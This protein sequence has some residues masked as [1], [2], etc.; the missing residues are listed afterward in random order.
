M[1]Q[2]AP[3]NRIERL[4]KENTKVTKI[5]LFLKRLMKLEINS[6]AKINPNKY[7]AVGL[8]KYNIP[9]NSPVNTGIPIKPKNI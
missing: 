8:R 9:V 6:V 5:R 7:P 1:S 3:N 2:I 4:A